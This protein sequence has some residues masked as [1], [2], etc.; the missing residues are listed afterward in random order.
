MKETNELICLNCGKSENDAPLLNVRFNGRMLWIC[1][2]CLPILIHRPF[3]LT[4][5]LAGME[6]VP[7][8]KPAH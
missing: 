3:Q 6:N 5:K 7:P 8:G 2:S 4:N 1:S